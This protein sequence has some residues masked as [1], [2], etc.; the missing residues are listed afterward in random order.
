MKGETAA[1]SVGADARVLQLDVTNQDYISAAAEC[2]R[3]ELGRLNV[4]V[5]NAGISLMGQPGRP[6]EEVGKSGRPSVASLTCSAASLSRQRCCR[7][8][9]KRRQRVSSTY[10]AARAP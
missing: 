6:L 7:S 9:V 1:K 4:L 2:I 5:N 3:S 8:F 10:R